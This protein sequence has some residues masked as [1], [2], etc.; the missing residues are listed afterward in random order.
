MKKEYEI[1]KNAEKV[2]L[3]YSGGLDTSVLVT[4]LKEQGVKEVICVSGNLGQVKDVEVLEK[5]ALSTGASKFYNFNLQEEFIEDYAF[6]ALKAGAKYENIYLLGTATARP[7]IAKKL[8]EVA[9]KEGSDVICH[10]CT[11]KGNDQVRFELSIKALDPDIKVVAPWRFWDIKGRSEEIDYAKKHNIPLQFSKEEDYSMDEN[12]WHLSHEGLDLENPESPANLDKILHWITPP[13]KA[14]DEAEI[15]KIGFEKGIPVSVN[16]ESL[17][18][19]DLVE[20]LNEIGKKHGIGIDDIVESRLVGMKSRGVYENPA[21]SIL[22]FAHEKLESLTLDSDTL[23]YKQH[24]ALKYAELVYNGK[25]LGSLKKN[26][27]AFVDS[28]QEY[29]TGEVGVKLYKG[30]MQPAGIFSDY[31]LYSEGLAT[32]EEDDV[33]NHFDATGFINLYGLS[34]KTYS[35]NQVKKGE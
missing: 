11:G 29:V 2:V 6:Q 3:A 1:L 28:S 24:V 30:S 21:G 13:E 9:K 12:V 33:Y 15:V 8:V 17:K 18:A 16:G 5:K 22:Y 32:F 4:W 14:S 23:H 20:K 7:L 25:W 19:I 26:L 34:L 27:D 35:S 31:S 10:G